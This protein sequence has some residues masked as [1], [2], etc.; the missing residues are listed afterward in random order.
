MRKVIKLLRQPEF[1]LLVIW[2]FLALTNWPFLAV[3][4][5]NGLLA[6]YEYLYVLWAMLILLLFCITRCVKDSFGDPTNRE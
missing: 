5:R 3:A 6:L 1:H 2:L 4:A